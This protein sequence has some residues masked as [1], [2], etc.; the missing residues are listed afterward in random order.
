MEAETCPPSLPLK[1]VV[2]NVQYETKS[3]ENKS[4]REIHTVPA[5]APLLFTELEAKQDATT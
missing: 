2:L 5:A 3:R 4:Q 1:L